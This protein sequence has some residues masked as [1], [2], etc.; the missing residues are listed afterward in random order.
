MSCKRLINVPTVSNISPLKIKRLIMILIS[1]LLPVE[2]SSNSHNNRL[3]WPL[4]QHNESAIGPIGT[5][6]I[7]KVS[8]MLN[9]WNPYK[10]DLVFVTML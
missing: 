9:V 3:K 1:K 10:C 7:T 4:Q 8:V 5:T 6:V 2:T